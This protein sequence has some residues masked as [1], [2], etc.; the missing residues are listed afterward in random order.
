MITGAALAQRARRGLRRVPRR[1]IVLAQ[2]FERALLVLVGRG[3]RDT[4]DL[5][6]VDDVDDAPVGDLRHGERAIAAS[7]AS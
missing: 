1:R 5:G 6:A 7:V 3:D 4:P 2:L